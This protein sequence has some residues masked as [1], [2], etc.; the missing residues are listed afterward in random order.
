MTKA[1]SKLKETQSEHTCKLEV[2]SNELNRVSEGLNK[3]FGK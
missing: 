3:A 1:E 2:K